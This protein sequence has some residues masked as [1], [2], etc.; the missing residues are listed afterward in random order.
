VKTPTWVRAAV[1]F[2][3]A[4]IARSTWLSRLTLETLGSISRAIDRDWLSK[5]IW[6]ACARV[7]WPEIELSPRQ[8]LVTPD[9]LVALRPHAGEFDFQCLF[10]RRLSYEPEVFAV[11]QG[12]LGQYGAIVEIGANVGVYTL[13]LAAHPRDANTRVI[14]LEPSGEAFR[15]LV[16]NVGLN[17]S[18]IRTAQLVTLNCAMA[19]RAGMK[20]FYEPLGHLTNGS[21]SKEF[22]SLFSSDVQERMVPCI[23]PLEL[24]QH[25]ANVQGAILIKL[26]CEGAEPEILV[27]IEPLIRARRPDII[28]EV[29]STTVDALNRIALLRDGYDK[30]QITQ[31]GCEPRPEFEATAFRDW[32][33]RPRARM[34]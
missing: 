17:R 15:R 31:D 3:L 8:T 22:A 12:L 10:S 5:R 4:G 16:D 1:D 6:N 26:D 21:F 11:L 32:L 18:V 19:D 7:T 33:A 29:T 20:P 2:A 25:L 23:G 14:A 9:T 27:A 30:F 34:N 13:F 24:E 28:V